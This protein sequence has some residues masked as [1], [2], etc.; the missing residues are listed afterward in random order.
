MYGHLQ[1]NDAC[2]WARAV[3]KH[4]GIATVTSTTDLMLL[5]A[6]RD[7]TSLSWNDTI[8]KS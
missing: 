5:T 8:A 3:I 7:S 6:T 4:V 2:S 1:V